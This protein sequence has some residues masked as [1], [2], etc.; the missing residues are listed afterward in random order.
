MGQ[1]K[2]LQ[3]AVNGWLKYVSFTTSPD[4]ISDMIRIRRELEN[5]TTVAIDL[6]HLPKKPT[7]HRSRPKRKRNVAS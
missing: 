7:K 1:G 6:S 2:L 5:R 3:R 4:D